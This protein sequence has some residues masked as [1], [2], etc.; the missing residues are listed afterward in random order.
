MGDSQSPGSRV[1]GAVLA[2]GRSSRMGRDKAFV[3]LD[4]RPLA[5]AVLDALREVGAAPVV[6]VGGDL[7]S[8]TRLGFDDGVPD[9]H[10]GEGPLGGILTALEAVVAD[11]VV[12]LGCDMPWVTAEALRELVAALDADPLADVAVA[13]SDRPEPLFAAWRRAP[14]RPI[15][16]QAFAEG[17]R[18]QH[19]ALGR[20]VV[21]PVVVRDPAVLRSANRPGDLPG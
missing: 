18:A 11:V 7:A 16:R 21:R 2:G 9:L 6:A 14:C 5:A 3:E 4:G 19:R 13:Q 10:P 15:L 12:V 17:V 1:A 20:F 8:L